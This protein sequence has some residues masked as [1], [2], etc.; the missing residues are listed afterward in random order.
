[1]WTHFSIIHHLPAVNTS[2]LHLQVTQSKQQPKEEINVK[3][4]FGT[5]SGPWVDLTFTSHNSSGQTGPPYQPA[6]T[7][8]KKMPP[9]L[10]P[11]CPV[12]NWLSPWKW[13]SSQAHT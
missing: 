1:M 10:L 9:W 8:C 11:D 3:C 2:R 12:N 7:S 6:V 5:C 4:F 13:S